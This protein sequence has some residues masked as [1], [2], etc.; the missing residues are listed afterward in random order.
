MAFETGGSLEEQFYSLLR[1]RRDLLHFRA[2]TLPHD[3]SISIRTAEEIRQ[4]FGL[5]RLDD[6]NFEH[7]EVRRLIDHVAVDDPVLQE[8]VRMRQGQRQIQGQNEHFALHRRIRALLLRHHRISRR[9]SGI[10]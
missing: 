6:K 3:L 9:S 1:L 4:I 7:F 10:R 8:V 2:F 5:F